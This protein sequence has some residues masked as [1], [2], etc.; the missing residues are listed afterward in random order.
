MNRKQKRKNWSKKGRGNQKPKRKK[1]L[2]KIKVETNMRWLKLFR[3]LK[4]FRGAQLTV[5]Q[6]ATTFTVET[7]LS[8]VGG[9]TIAANLIVSSSTA[10]LFAVAFCLADLAQAASWTAI[11]DQ[12]RIDRVLVRFKSRNNAVSVFNIASPNGSV[13]SGFVVIDRDD[14]AAPASL[15]ALQ[16]YDTAEYFQGENDVL[17]EIGPSITPAIYAS[18]A[19]SA[20]AVEQGEHLWVDVANTSVPYY[21]IKGGLSG[22]TNTTTSSWVWDITAEYIVSF[23]NV[24]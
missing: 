16:E 14:S 1:E 21:G 20:Y 18:G 19:F 22:L 4:P 15:A 10:V 23:K 13:P 6:F 24:R 17:V 9:G 5:K 12:Y 7:G 11:F 3:P 2:Q 8:N